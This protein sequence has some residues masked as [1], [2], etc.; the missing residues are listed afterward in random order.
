[1]VSV[2]RLAVGFA[3]ASELTVAGPPTSAGAVKEIAQGV[4]AVMFNLLEEHKGSLNVGARME[5]ASGKPAAEIELPSGVAA[6][7]PKM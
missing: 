1:M 6:T 7:T 5:V 2:T 4:G 3:T